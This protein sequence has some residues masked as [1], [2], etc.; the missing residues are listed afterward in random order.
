MSP[1]DR[2]ISFIAASTLLLASLEYLIP[3][4]LPFLRL[5]LANLPL[6]LILQYFDYPAYFLL[7]LLKAIGQGMVSGTLFSY[8]FFI[9]LA[10]TMSSG[11]AMKALKGL[12][13]DKVSLVGISVVGAFFS[14]LAQLQVAAWVAYGSTIWVAAP[15]M[16]GL[17]MIT[18][19]ILGF[20]A[21]RY[22]KSG[23]FPNAFLSDSFEVALP[24]IEERTHYVER[25]IAM[26]IA[27]GAILLAQGPLPLFANTLLM[28][29]I[30]TMCRRKIRL[31]PP[32]MLL[33]S[34]MVL[35]L[36]EPNG[37]VIFTLGSL[38][39][40][41]GSIALALTKGL[42][43]I[44]LLSASQSLVS[45][46]P[47]L[48]GKLGSLLLMA[49]SYFGILTAC[50]RTVKG[51]FLERVDGALFCGAEGKLQKA[52]GVQKEQGS[53]VP[54]I[55]TAVIVVGVSIASRVLPSL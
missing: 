29:A 54:I 50:F 47:R 4:P 43:L 55:I 33:F 14:N 23:S 9:S 35:A 30:Q 39:L 2:K 13:K 51:S 6:L 7:L 38:A 20:L 25:T 16:L 18:S 45:S 5:G 19:I 36:F 8:L 42:R 24:T 26:V 41:K 17:G 31:I 1:T 12:L 44:A 40:T 22:I 53:S 52:N 48:K 34:L 28:Y 27:I 49:L 11:F 37:A 10:G 46:N 3:K 21:E 32:L 15:L